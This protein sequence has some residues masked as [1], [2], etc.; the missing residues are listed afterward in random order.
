MELFISAYS[1]SISKRFAYNP[2]FTIG[3]R[4]DYTNLTQMRWRYQDLENSSACSSVKKY[5]P[6]NAVFDKNE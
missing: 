3:Q 5:P 6:E 4:W 2:N 1:H